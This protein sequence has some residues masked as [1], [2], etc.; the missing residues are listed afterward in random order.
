MNIAILMDPIATVDPHKDTTLAILDAARARQWSCSYF[1]LQDVWIQDEGKVAANVTP[2]TVQKG[3]L[4]WRTAKAATCFLTQFDIILIRKDP[5]F[6]LTYLYVTQLLDLVERQGVLVSNKPQALRSHNEKLAVLQFPELCSPT[7]VSMDLNILHAFWEKHRSVIFKPLDAMGGSSV[8]HVDATGL[9][10]N[11]IL[12]TLSQHGTRYIMAQRYIS[13][14]PHTGDKRIILIQGEP[15]PYALARFPKQGESRANL[16][17]GGTGQVVPIT[18]R[19]R[20]LCQTL[21]SHLQT[22]SLHFVG[23]DVIG[24]YITEINVTSPTCARQ[25]TAETN[26]DIAGQ[27]LDSLAA[28]RKVKA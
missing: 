3:G 23:L 12:E 11:V 16:A 17:V 28:L 27:Y 6:D 24:D 2:I 10:I 21:K 15:I 14:L 18:E 9:N 20:F 5:P 8:F 7:L 25:I 4:T 22:Q 19:D 13:D 26:I 1:T